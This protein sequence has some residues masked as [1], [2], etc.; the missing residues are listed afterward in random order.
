MKIETEY[1]FLDSNAYARFMINGRLQSLLA[2]I[3]KKFPEVK[4]ILCKELVIELEDVCTRERF[5]KR[6]S[7]KGIDDY[8]EIIQAQIKQLLIFADEYIDDEITILVPLP[9]NDPDDWYVFNLGLHYNCTVIS[10][11]KHIKN[12]PN[13]PFP[14]L[15]LMN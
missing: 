14:F 9:N 2:G 11:D 15:L 4:L 6:A 7:K 10:N 1:L 13:K 8:V 5:L 12:I 3:H